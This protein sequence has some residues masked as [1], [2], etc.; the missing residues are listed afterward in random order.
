M[1]TSSSVTGAGYFSGSEGIPAQ[2]F[3]RRG[4]AANFFFF[5][6]GLHL[7]QNEVPTLRVESQPSHS[8]SHSDAG[9]LLH[10]QPALQLEA[11]SDP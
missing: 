6:L 2:E 7:W 4:K 3:Q 8:H 10:L 5:F 9:S 11:T 1:N